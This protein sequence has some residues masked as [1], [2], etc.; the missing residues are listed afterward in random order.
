MI[1]LRSWNEQEVTGSEHP[2]SWISRNPPKPFLWWQGHTYLKERTVRCLTVHGPRH[3]TW[4]MTK[5]GSVFRTLSISV[6]SSLPVQEGANEQPPCEATIQVWF[7]KEEIPSAC[8]VRDVCVERVIYHLDN[9]YLGSYIPPLLFKRRRYI[10]RT[11]IWRPYLSA[12]AV[13]S[14]QT[15]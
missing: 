13:L 7:Q 3:V 1:I 6:T 15:E 10:S 11:D 4:L 8:S 2:V 9:K 12:T 5:A 14:H